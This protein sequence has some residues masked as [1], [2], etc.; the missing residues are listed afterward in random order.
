NCRGERVR[1]RCRLD[2]EQPWHRSELLEAEEH[3]PRVAAATVGESDRIRSA[4]ELLHELERERL[5]ALDAVRV[6]GVD[7]RVRAAPL[8]LAGGSERF[9]EGA[10]HLEYAGAVHA[11]LR[12]LRAG[13]SP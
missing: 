5:L 12:D 6:Q 4:A 11:R 7:E 9:V 13:R 1:T 10:A 8:E 2:R 3:R